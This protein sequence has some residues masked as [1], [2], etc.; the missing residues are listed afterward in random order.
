MGTSWLLLL[1]QDCYGMGDV[2]LWEEACPGNDIPGEVHV[3]S[4]QILWLLEVMLCL[5]CRHKRTLL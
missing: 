4:A 3:M 5:K 1:V 2:P